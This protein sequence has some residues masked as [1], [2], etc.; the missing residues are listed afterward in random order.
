VRVSGVWKRTQA[1]WIDAWPCLPFLAVG[2]IGT[3]PAAAYQPDA[4]RSLDLPAYALVVVAALALAGRRLPGT[5]L[6]VN[7]A[8]VATYLAAGY[9][10][11]PILLTVPAA[12]YGVAVAWPPGRAAAVV[13]ADFGVVIVAYFTKTVSEEGTDP[14]SVDAFVGGAIVLVALAAGITVRVR[15]EAAV[16]MRAEQALRLASEERLRMAQDLHD[17]IGHGLAAMAM[18]TGVA[19]HVLDRDPAEARQAMEAVRATSR[20]A[21]DNL[22]AGLER[23]RGDE[24][25]RRAP[26]PRGPGLDGLD[27]L[28]DR[29]R[30]AGVEV[31]VDVQ[32][33]LGLA[34]SVDA[35][36][37]RIV[38]EALTNVLRHAGAAPTRVLV[39]R[40]GADLLVEV[41][42]T[43]AGTATAPTE[44][45]GIRGMRAQAERLGGTLEA[46][47]LPGGGFSVRA[48]MPVEAGT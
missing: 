36:A 16:C 23:L 47:P 46:G 28:A 22:R 41:T 2:L 5:A 38:R 39:R 26:A 10:F 48:R 33:N 6:A 17:I 4:A 14:A 42:D 3:G 31:S 40:D 8:A 37:F 18:Q 29:V 43:G 20:E 34:Y 45:L 9:P 32:P 7:G 21:L 13:A 15:R 30:T 35:A 25:A 12:M 44:G 24:P 11:G 19:L 27:E 1:W